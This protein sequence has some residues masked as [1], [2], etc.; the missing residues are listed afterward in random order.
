M[1]TPEE[2]EALRAQ[3]AAKKAQPRLN[4]LYNGVEYPEGTEVYAWSWRL[5]GPEALGIIVS[6]NPSNRA[7]VAVDKSPN[8]RRWSNVPRELRR[9]L[10]D[11]A[12]PS[13]AMVID[14]RRAS[15]LAERVRMVDEIARLDAE[16]AQLGEQ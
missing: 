2:I 7:E 16:I 15:L 8:P 13:R 4:A 3:R 11:V 5:R 14:A 12:Y 10:G 6:V 9:K 1:R